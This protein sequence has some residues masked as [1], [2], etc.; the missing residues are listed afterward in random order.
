LYTQLTENGQTVVA[1]LIS[2]QWQLSSIPYELGDIMKFLII[3]GTRFLG[4]ALVDAVLSAGHEVTLFNRG[5]TNPELYPELEWLKGD[6]DGGLD[7]LQGRRWDAVFDTCGY[8]PRLV[9]DSAEMLADAVDHYTFISTLS[10]YSDPSRVGMDEEAPLG[11]I[12]DELIEEINDESYGPLKVLCESAVTATMH[13]ASPPGRALLVRSG[14]IV[15]PHDPSD[16]FT[17]WPYRL[18]RGGDVLAPG[19]PRAPVQFID[20]RDIAA[21]TVRAT[22]AGLTGPYNVAGPNYELSMEQLLETCRQLI[23]RPASFCWVDDD[24][25]AEKQVAAYTEM[26]L[27]LPAE[28]AGWSSVNCQKAFDAGLVCRPLAETV[29]DTL[30]WSATRPADYEWRG[31]MSTSREAELLLAWQQQG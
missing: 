26:P 3:G 31:G 11:S 25:L 6:R 8:L 21:W 29:A 9:R 5:Q 27:W 19:D 28:Y 4:R 15:G 16:R 1:L 14:L 23:G 20:V 13:A 12:E 7:V 24:F 30:A 18:S 22:E 17:Y 2:W 10:V